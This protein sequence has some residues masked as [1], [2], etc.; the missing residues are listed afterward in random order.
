MK[1]IEYVVDAP[2]PLS[3]RDFAL[4]EKL[5]TIQYRI[6]APNLLLCVPCLDAYLS[7]R[8]LVIMPNM[9]LSMW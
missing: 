4:L 5:N 1:K 8:T 7:Y 6:S 2:G 9:V 3:V